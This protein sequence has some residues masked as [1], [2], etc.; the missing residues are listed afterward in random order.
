MMM[1]DTGRTEY[2]RAMAHELKNPLGAAKGALELILDEE[3]PGTAE[4]R[5]RMVELALRNVEKAL[6]L[7]DE[8]GAAA[9]RED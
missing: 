2:R 7:V 3:M 1:T 9:A 8:I 4:D 5:Q 6:H